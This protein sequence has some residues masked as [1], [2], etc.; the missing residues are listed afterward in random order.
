ME[1]LNYQEKAF[2]NKKTFDD[3]HKNFKIKV[4]YFIKI[5]KKHSHGN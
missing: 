5:H 2:K 3:D 1:N 4:V